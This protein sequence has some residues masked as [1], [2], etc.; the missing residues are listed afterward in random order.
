MKV[1]RLYGPLDLRIEDD[2]IPKPGPGEALIEVKAAGICGSDVH[3][4]VDGRIGDVVVR[5]PIV[6]GHEF[7]GV[8]RELGSGV[9]GLEVGMRVAVEP[10]IPCWKCEFCRRGDYNLCPDMKF[11]G[12][13]PID[14]CYKEYHVHPAE[15]LFPMPS[16]MS[17]EVGAMIEPL[18]VSVHAVDLARIR[19]GARVAVL[20][21]GSIGLTVLQMA[22]AAGASEIYVTDKLEPRLRMALKLGATEAI[23]VS[24]GGAVGPI[25]EL[26]SGRGADVVFEAA[27]APETPGEAVE[28]A[29]PGGAVIII[30]I[31]EEDRISFAASPARR[32]G[33]TIRM[34]RRMRGTYPR[35]IDLISRGIVDVASL[36]THR[37]KLDRIEEAFELVRNYRDGVV[38]AVV[39]L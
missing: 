35:S 31:P 13:F 21:A 29:K 20:G 5:E 16:D 23:K 8:V 39:E 1:A 32:K 34:I 26:T 19:P 30:G 7:S 11:C 3:Y 12:T 18:S 38:K 33:L 36:V 28:L 14:G 6:L 24:D 22:K 25:K 17:F 37:F 4:Y 2:E 10:G 27:G 15:L 9:E